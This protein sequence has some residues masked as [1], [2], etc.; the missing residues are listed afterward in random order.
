MFDGLQETNSLGAV[1]GGDIVE[2]INE[3]LGSE[4]WQVI[5]TYLGHTFRDTI[6]DARSKLSNKSAVVNQS[7]FSILAVSQL[8]NSYLVKQI[9]RRYL[10]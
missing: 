6:G 5:I 8:F 3:E 4:G 10:S 7:N 1:E 9:S 2:K